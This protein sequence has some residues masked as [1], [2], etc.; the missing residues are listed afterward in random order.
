MLS[1]VTAS[2]LGERTS[3]GSTRVSPRDWAG[4]SGRVRFDSVIV[5]TRRS[6]QRRHRRPAGRL[7]QGQDR[8]PGLGVPARDPG[9]LAGD[10][11]GVVAP[12]CETAVTAPVEPHPVD[13]LHGVG[14][15]VAAG[16]A[17]DVGRDRLRLIPGHQAGVP[18]PQ[19]E[20]LLLLSTGSRTRPSLRVRRSRSLDMAST[21]PVGPVH[22]SRALIGGGF[23]DVLAEDRQ[24][25]LGQAERAQDRRLPPQRQLEP[26]C[27]ERPAGRRC[28]RPA[29]SARPA[30][31][32][33]ISGAAPHQD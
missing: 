4:I 25:G 12:G 27:S 21:A 18:G 2:G 10:R 11:Q 14:G 6:E 15:V 19:R 32:A 9:Q 17:A 13:D 5:G 3:Y 30:A 24:L 7:E 31:E 28:R 29:G 16:L 23:G 22:R 26:P 20:R 8:C 33:L 1:A